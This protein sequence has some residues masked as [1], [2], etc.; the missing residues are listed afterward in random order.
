VSDLEPAPEEAPAGD[1]QAPSPLTIPEFRALLPIGLSVTLGFGLVV[2][3]LPLFAKS[4]GIGLTLV[5]LVQLIFGMTRFSFGLI[6]GLVVDRFGVRASTVTGVLIVSASSYAAG[7]AQN[8]PQLVLAR[9]FGGAGSA[10]FIAGLMNRILQIVPPGSMGR[11]TG[12]SRASFL[13][14]LAIGPAVGGVLKDQL[15]FRAPF[16]IY[17]T[18]LLITALIAW[19]AM[20]KKVHAAEAERKAPL[21]ALR[22]ARPLFSDKRYLT[23]LFATAAGWWLLSGPAQQIGSVYAQEELGFSG[24]AY[25]ISAALLAVGELIILLPAG[26]AADYKGRRFVLLPSLLAAFAC[27][28]AIGQIGGAPGLLFPL[29]IVLGMGAAAGGVAAGGLLADAVPKGGSGTAVG[30]NQMAG[31]LGYMIAPLTVGAVAETMGYGA[32]Y[33]FGAIPALLVFLYALKLPRPKTPTV[34]D[35]R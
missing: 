2:P 31:D 27:T 35:G 5:G 28:A 19:F 3:V 17:G 24:T 34:G 20:A 6:G 29:M 32:A 4:F 11:A 9:G 18:G 33:V 14:G 22:A 30:V 10:L 23:A 7:L 15:G 16:H 25:G 8:F 21:E 13:I 1:D 26:K 12:I